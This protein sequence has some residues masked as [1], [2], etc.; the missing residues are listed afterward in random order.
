LWYEI[1]SHRTRVNK[2]ASYRRENIA[3]AFSHIGHVRVLNPWQTISYLIDS[4]FDPEEQV[5]YLEWK[6][7]FLDEEVDE[8]G[9]WL[10]GGSTAIYQWSF[11]NTWLEFV[12]R[13]HSKWYSSLYTATINGQ[14]QQVPGIDSTI[15]A[16]YLDL[17]LT[18][19]RTYPILVVMNYDGSLG[20]TE[21]VLTLSPN[22]NDRWTYYVS[23]VTPR[24]FQLRQ[25]WALWTWTRSV[26]WWCYTRYVHGEEKVSCYKEIF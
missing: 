17:K 4:E 13:N 15:Y 20:W 21:E 22:K 24:T 12:S 1:I 10:C 9:W 8:Y 14:E 11:L 25:W 3:R 2:D 19:K 7:I 26:L 6:A 5:K 23:E 18:N 16:P